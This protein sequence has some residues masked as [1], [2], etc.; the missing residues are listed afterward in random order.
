M[1]KIKNKIIGITGNSGSGKSSVCEIL[2]LY[3]NIF[4]ISADQIAHEIILPGKLAYNNLIKVF[5]DKI[6]S[7]DLIYIDR[8][9]LSNIAFSSSENIK[10]L[11]AI[12]HKIIIDEIMHKINSLKLE[13][14]NYDLI[15]IDAPL[16]IE[17][18][19][20]KICDEVWLIYSEKKFLFDRL[21]Q[22]EKISHEQIKI[23]L[24][25]QID[26]EQAKRFA[27]IIIY[28]NKSKLALNKQ[29]KKILDSDK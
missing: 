12:T 22:R 18:G 19:L 11:N 6:L 27:D 9:K 25:N 10:K 8:K 3:K 15:V 24:D 21:S 7:D 26:F 14:N 16:L 4:L 23:R 28:N 20:N 29:I 17:T 5:G 13:K 1:I 2:S